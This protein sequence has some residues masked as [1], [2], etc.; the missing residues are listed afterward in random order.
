MN[1][2]TSPSIIAFLIV[3][4]RKF[5]TEIKDDERS[6]RERGRTIFLPFPSKVHRKGVCNPSHK[7]RFAGESVIIPASS[8]LLAAR[9]IKSLFEK[10]ISFF[11]CLSSVFRLNS[12]SLRLKKYRTSLR[13]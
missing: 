7:I 5:P 2:S 9:D 1:L 3:S 11:K 10:L 6:V 12:S 13:N 4:V 8:S